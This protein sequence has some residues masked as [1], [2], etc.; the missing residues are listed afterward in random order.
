MEDTGQSSPKKQK[1]YALKFY[2]NF[3]EFGFHHK[4]V[5]GKQQPYCLT[6]SKEFSP[7]SLKQYNLKRHQQNAQMHIHQPLVEVLSTSNLF[8]WN[9]LNQKKS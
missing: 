9:I 6:C 7:N 3:L 2:E 5:D 1:R 8:W 4:I